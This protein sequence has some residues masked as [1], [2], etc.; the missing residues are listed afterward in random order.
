MRGIFGIPCVPWNASLFL[1]H[2]ISSRW[3]R[4]FQAS[5]GIGRGSR[6]I[7]RGCSWIAAYAFARETAGLPK[8]PGVPALS[9]CPARGGN[10]YA[11]VREL[12]GHA[13]HAIWWVRNFSSP[14]TVEFAARSA[15][16]AIAA[17]GLGL[18]SPVV[19]EKNYKLR[20]KTLS[21]SLRANLCNSRI[22]ICKLVLRSVHFRRRVERQSS[23]PYCSS[24]FYLLDS[25]KVDNRKLRSLLIF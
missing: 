17:L 24:C 6:C 13:S 19:R 4:R 14:T 12:R 7:P 18:G 16:S 15:A 22:S 9:H 5:T 21:F 8:E 25:V 1:L 3:T 11:F 23:C 20:L 2:N 10:L